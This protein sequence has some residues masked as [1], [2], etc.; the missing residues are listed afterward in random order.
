MMLDLSRDVACL[1]GPL[2]YNNQHQDSEERSANEWIPK[3]AK[4]SPRDVVFSQARHYGDSTHTRPSM[5]QMSLG[6][7]WSEEQT[8]RL[9]SVR[10]LLPFRWLLGQRAFVL[11]FAFRSY[12]ACTLGFSLL[13]GSWIGV[14]N[15][16]PDDA[17]IMKA[18]LRGDLITVR[19]LFRTGRAK[20]SDSTIEFNYNPLTNA[21]ASGNV[22]LVE[23]LLRNGANVNGLFGR[24]QTSPLAWALRYRHEE[25]VRLLLERGADV[26]H[27]SAIGWT[28][29]FYL[30]TETKPQTKPSLTFLKMMTAKNAFYPFDCDLTDVA[31]WDILHRAAAF[32][33]PEDVRTLIALGARKHTLVGELNWKP[34]QQAVF[35]NNLPTLIELLP[36]YPG[37]DINSPDE[38]GW[39][40]LHIAASAG[41]SDIVRHLLKLGADPFRRSKPSWSH[42]PETLY[43]QGWTPAE[44]ARAQNQE[45]YELYMDALD[46]F[47]FVSNAGEHQHFSDALEYQFG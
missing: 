14:T 2:P 34:I 30:W 29:M 36:H 17:E 1:K 27:V 22:E 40:F 11:D 5:L 47:A 16:I 25:V 38:R 43:G 23:F 9:L 7:S 21:V 3:N 32:G 18:S 6:T 20:A 37:L 26:N 31:G 10:S 42:M 46:E 24:R 41:N 33:T 8:T 45:R 28:P 35:F 39:T 12:T 13:S 4:G 15:I 19:E 44:V